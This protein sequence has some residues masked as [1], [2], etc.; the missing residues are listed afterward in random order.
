MYTLF[1]LIGAPV[2]LVTHSL[3]KLM[4]VYDTIMGAGNEDMIAAR[5]IDP[6][7]AEELQRWLKTVPPEAL[8]PFL[9]ALT[10]F[11]RGKN[12]FY[13]DKNIR[14]NQQRALVNVLGW[15]VANKDQ[16]FSATK[17]NATQLL[18]EKAVSRMNVYGK[19]ENDPKS[20]YC[21]KKAWLDTFMGWSSGL[22]EDAHKALLLVYNGYIEK[23]GGHINQY[24]ELI[25]EKSWLQS[26][27]TMGISDTTKVW[28]YT[29]PHYEK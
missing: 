18:F 3:P 9:L 2:F 16:P 6:R 7:Y 4:E 17:P 27:N 22:K 15:L 1:L 14:A 20:T 11:Q 10:S 21:L 19:K 25:D 28:R 24:C 13:F 12:W 8:G 26:V 29:G 23:L 5:I